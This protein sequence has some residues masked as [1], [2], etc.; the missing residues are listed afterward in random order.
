MADYGRKIKITFD[1]NFHYPSIPGNEDKFTISA[2]EPKYIPGGPDVNTEY[3]VEDIEIDGSRVEKTDFESG[4][5]TDVVLTDG[6]LVLGASG[7]P[8]VVGATASAT[9]N[10]Y[11]KWMKCIEID[12]GGPD[13]TI[14]EFKYKTYGYSTYTY[15]FR[16]YEKGS[17]WDTDN[18]SLKWTKSISLTAYTD[19][20]IDLSTENLVLE[21]G[22]SY[23]FGHYSNNYDYPRHY[24]PNVSAYPYDS[25]DGN[26]SLVGEV[27][28]KQSTF[29]TAWRAGTYNIKFK[30]L[31]YATLGTWTFPLDCNTI[32]D[33]IYSFA[34]WT[35]D[36]PTDTDVKVYSA[37]NTSNVTEPT[38]WTEQTEEGQ[39]ETISAE[40]DLT[41]KYLWIKVEL[42]TTDVNSTPT[43]SSPFFRVVHVD[44]KKSIVLLL[45]ELFG[46]NNANSDITID[47]DS[48]L[49]T[50]F[51]DLTSYGPVSDFT[52]TFTPT[53][54][55]P[56]NNPMTDDAVSIG[57]TDMSVDRLIITFK[58][59]YGPEA[60]S[61]GLSDYAITRTHV[62]DLPP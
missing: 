31:E 42:S 23:M 25:A 5:E 21:A 3:T 44:D 10:D 26:V 4:N 11:G 58:E 48:T 35:T 32:T 62:D 16:L 61:I 36:L 20:T 37:V 1:G 12:A 41:G 14:T 6:T 57:L 51:G 8:E 15:T 34:E 47:Y 17:N 27:Y 13:Y 2:N 54:L 39:F 45:E 40:D 52:E 33:A 24:Y 55:A 30:K 28:A 43:V 9:S 19:H 18:G 29:Y 50:L 59:G 49:G 56:A 7:T 22:K 53:G 60:V 46:F 38:V